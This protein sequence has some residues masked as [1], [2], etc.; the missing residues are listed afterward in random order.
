M[1][2]VAQLSGG[3][4]VGVCEVSVVRVGGR[5]KNILRGEG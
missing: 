5:V 2:C 4:E 3:N 1:F